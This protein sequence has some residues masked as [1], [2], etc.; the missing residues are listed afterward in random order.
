LTVALAVSR[1]ALGMALTALFLTLA[2]SRPGRRPDLT[3]RRILMAFAA[4]A[5]GMALFALFFGL[6]P[7]CNRF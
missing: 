7:G 3:R 1:A 2:A 6:V 5:L 4:L